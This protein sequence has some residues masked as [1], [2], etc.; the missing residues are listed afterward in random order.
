MEI[1]SLFGF[2]CLLVWMLLLAPF[3]LII[4]TPANHNAKCDGP[5]AIQRH[6]HRRLSDPIEF[7]PEGNRSVAGIPRNPI[8]SFATVF[9]PEACV[10]LN[11]FRAGV[12][13]Y[14]FPFARH[15]SNV[16]ARCRLLWIRLVSQF[17]NGI[18]TSGLRAFAA[19][20]LRQKARC[21]CSCA[22]I[23]PKKGETPASWDLNFR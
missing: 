7:A 6:C 10:C 18:L 9:V 23:S 2:G 12:P 4:Y 14:G 20:L 11:A 22:G 15:P 5:N 8:P 13:T 19:F 16:G 3:A 1:P 17:R 21:G